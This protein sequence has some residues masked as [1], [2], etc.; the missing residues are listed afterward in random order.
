MKKIISL[1][2]VLVM[3][4]SLAACSGGQ[5]EV[6]TA[7]GGDVTEAPS[8]TTAGETTGKKKNNNTKSVNQK[9]VSDFN[10][11]S[12]EGITVATGTSIE[13]VIA[14]LPK[15]LYVYVP[16]SNTD[17][18]SELFSD[19]FSS[20]DKWT[21]YDPHET[22]TIESN[23]AT[24]A[25]TTDTA[26]MAITDAP[27]ASGDGVYVNYA[28]SATITL[29]DGFTGNC[30]LVLRGSDFTGTSGDGYTGQFI[31]LVAGTD[32]GK[33]KLT[34]GR[35]DGSWHGEHDEEFD[36]EGSTYQMEVIVYN[37]KY[38]VKIDG[39]AIYT[40]EIDASLKQGVAGYRSWNAGCEVEN[41]T[42][43]SL[44]AEDYAEFEG[45]YCELVLCPVTWSCTDYD[46]AKEKKSQ[47]G[48]IGDMTEGLGGKKAQ[49]KVIVT[50]DPTYVETTAAVTTAATPVTTAGE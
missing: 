5:T 47:Y 14:K 34:I 13:D 20:G 44:G 23:K 38:V 18:S 11:E 4:A 2:L 31:G 28:V 8:V 35:A 22:I 43:R 32:E 12:V 42:V 10:V 40:G 48:F 27:W 33:G 29:L 3:A 17:T 19:D 37:D 45:G 16:A 15:E 36:H 25:G 9:V 41:F 39:N 1:L 26:Y 7:A 46:P 50:A 30:G 49:V 24:Y 21:L 6:T